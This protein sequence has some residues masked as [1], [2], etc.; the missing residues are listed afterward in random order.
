LSLGGTAPTV[1]NAANEMAVG[2]FLKGRIR[3]D[4]IPAIIDR[5]LSEHSIRL[6]PGLQDIVEADRHTRSF[7]GTLC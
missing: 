1:L 5:A 3:F 4:R 6:S 2:A 7:V